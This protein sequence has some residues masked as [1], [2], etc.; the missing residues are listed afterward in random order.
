M[1]SAGV[2]PRS[3]GGVE[4]ALTGELEMGGEGE[5]DGEQ[6]PAASAIRKRAARILV[7]IER[8]GPRRRIAQLL[9]TQQLS[10]LE[11]G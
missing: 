7:L 1:V 11:R 8:M 4:G 6:W 10:T 2:R 9:E 5:E 3:R